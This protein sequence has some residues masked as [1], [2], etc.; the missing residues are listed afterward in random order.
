MTNP[1]KRMYVLT[2]E[3]YLN[4]KRYKKIPSDNVDGQSAVCPVDGHVFP[5][6][7]VLA[8]HM[9]T[10]YNGFKCNICGELFKTKRGLATHLK[11]H[12]PQVHPSTHSIFNSSTS[13]TYI[14]P[15]TTEPPVVSTKRK[16][17]K[18]RSTLNFKSIKWLTLK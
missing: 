5:N 16:A 1:Y 7:N 10:H 15:E 13:Q 6:S 17:Y 14:A 11:N 2:E 9:K 18:Q 3:E 8:H 12:P 4:Y